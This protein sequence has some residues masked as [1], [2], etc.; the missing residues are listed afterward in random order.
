[1]RST[2]LSSVLFD[3]FGCS[4]TTKSQVD[5]PF[6]MEMGIVADSEVAARN[7]AMEV[8][9]G[10]LWNCSARNGI[11]GQNNRNFTT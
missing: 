8:M 11:D 7:V 4:A 2:M 1:M 5:W 6:M 3:L 10:M 9:L